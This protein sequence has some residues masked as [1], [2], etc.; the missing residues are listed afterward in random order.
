MQI[1]FKIY[2]KMDKDETLLKLRTKLTQNKLASESATLLN[3]W[4]IKLLLHYYHPARLTCYKNI[5][6]NYLGKDM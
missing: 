1:R 2:A 5:A 3:V 4:L 6:S